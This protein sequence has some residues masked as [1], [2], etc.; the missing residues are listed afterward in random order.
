MPGI[1]NGPAR[2]AVVVLLLAGGTVAIGA[3][4]AAAGTARVDCTYSVTPLN[5]AAVTGG[6]ATIVNVSVAGTGCSWTAASNDAWI[7]VTSGAAGTSTGP[8]GLSIAANTGATAR[9]GTVIIAGQTLT[10]TQSGPGPCLYG[11]VP[12]TKG[13]LADGDSASPAVTTGAACAWTAI[14]N[15]AWIAVT[16]SATTVGSGTVT[17]T[18]GGNP[19]A[20]QRIGTV[21]IAGQTYTVTQAAQPGCTYTISPVTKSAIA[22]GETTTAA[23]TTP[24]GCAW[25]ANTAAEWITITSSATGDG[26]GT[27]TMAIE[28]NPGA[29]QRSAVVTIAGRTFMVTQVGTSACAYTLDATV[30][31]SPAG[32]ETASASV[33]TGASCAWTAASGAP[34]IIVSSG[35][36]GTGTGT[37]TMTI[38]SNSGAQRIGT[39]T[40]AGQSFSVTQAPGSCSYTVTPATL[41][42]PAA[43]LASSVSVATAAGC[44]W[45]A[46]GM[47]SWIA[48]TTATQSG[49]GLLPYTIGVN[50]G[51]FR[52]VIL[53]IAGQPV[54]V[55][56]NGPVPASPLNLRVV[57]DQ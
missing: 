3:S 17:L 8:V 18:I 19:G 27:V 4:P 31:S 42:V 32:G 36:S 15:S 6:E 25:T 56:Q 10:I 47:P 57:R 21:T 11:V 7:T 45:A 37:V 5:R 39:V 41:A 9:T 46:S 49:S 54:T 48:A 20:T 50:T 2:R 53:T 38:A 23:V 29:T 40:I 30:R 43:G 51:V 44:S 55:T 52:S 34:W 28:P 26:N 22:A 24:A 16:S 13:A 33:T 1:W 35:S 12:L 14:S